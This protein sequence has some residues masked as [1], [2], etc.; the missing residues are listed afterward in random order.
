MWG[1]QHVYILGLFIK[2]AS[3]TQGYCTEH[4]TSDIYY[5]NPF[6]SRGIYGAI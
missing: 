6:R 5:I 1:V 2:D 3:S 4:I